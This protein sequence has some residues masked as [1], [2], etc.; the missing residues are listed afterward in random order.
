MRTKLH[1]II[2]LLLAVAPQLAQAQVEGDSLLQDYERYR[3][4]MYQNFEGFRQQAYD[5]FERFLAEAWTEYNSIAGQISIYTS[6]KPENTPKMQLYSGTH[7]GES[8][9]PFLVEPI[10]SARPPQNA[11]TK[12]PSDPDIVRVNFYGHNIDFHVP[13]ALRC[14]AKSSRESEVAKYY[15]AMHSQEEATRKLQVEINHAVSQMGLNEWGYFSLLR[16][17]SEKIFADTNDCVLFCFYMLH[18]N[19]FKARVGRGQ[20]SKNLLLLLAIDNSKEIY[21]STFFRINGTKY[22]I[23][24]GNGIKGEN[25]Y[26]YNEKADDRGLKEIGLDFTKQLNIAA[27]DMQRKLRLEKADINLVIPYS[28]SHLRYYDE[29]PMTVFPIYFKTPVSKEAELSL[30][31]TFDDLAK[32]NDKVQMVDIILNFV[33]T[34]FAYKIDELQFGREKYFFPEEVIGLPFSDCEDR[35]ALFA[36]MVRRF[37]GL[38]VIGVLYADHLATAVYFGDNANPKGQ[39]IM[40]KGKRFVVCDPTY[41]NASI[42]MMTPKYAKARYEIINIY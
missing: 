10:P 28:S 22:Y 34:A 39:S 31:N 40:H 21:S 8:A 19:G 26:S 36:W 20:Q 33:Q 5:E 2:I 13:Q 7:D 11:E 3:E 15:K 35:S 24:Y 14:K 16:T 12:Q 4:Q 29:I 18:S 25:V 23:V 17:I 32:K 41:Q 1:F 27:C 37:T 6:K 42:G 30:A 9:A 38:E